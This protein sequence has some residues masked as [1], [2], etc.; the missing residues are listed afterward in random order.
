MQIAERVFLVTGGASGLGR[1]VAEHLVAAGGRVVIADIAETGAETASALGCRFVRTDVADEVAGRAAVATAL[2]AYGGLDG[3]VTCAGIVA[4]AR[5]LGRNGPHDLD[6]FARTVRVNLVGTFNMVRLAA[7]AMAA[8]EPD[9]DGSRGVVVTTSSIAA[10]DG[11]VGQA[12]YAASKGG[13]ASLTLPLARDLAAH[14]IRVVSVAPGIFET[15]MMAG[16]PAEVQEALGR[17]VPFP[18]RLGRPSEFAALVAHIIGNPML[19]GEVIRLDGAL[20]MAPR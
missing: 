9:P 14:G 20:R 11:Q 17:S 16:L 2:E 4:G 1:A 12:A 10:F 18:P 3:L 13:V 15:P 6:A 8:R 7:E 19:N 5:V